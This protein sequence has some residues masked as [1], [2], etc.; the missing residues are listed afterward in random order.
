MKTA[1]LANHE[2][3]KFDAL[4]SHWWDLE[5]EFKT[6]HQ[7]NPLRLGFIE[8]HAGLLD[9]KR[10]LD[11]GCGGGILSEAMAA[12]GALVTGIDM[13]PSPLQIAALHAKGEHLAGKPEINYQQITAEEF[14]E[15]HAAEFDIVTC[16]EL[17]EHVPD[18][19]SLISACQKLCTANGHVFFSTLNRNPKSFLLA[20]VGA[21]YLTAMLPKGT[22]HYANF[23]RPS[24]LSQSCRDAGL[25]PQRLAGIHYNPLNRK[26]SLN[27]DVSVNY[28]LH[29]HN[30]FPE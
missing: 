5:G 14:A 16:M 25:T 22:H 23:I 18:P 15:E 6:L 7:V 20:I 13:A 27:R 11:V 19:G 1:N 4:A 26:F 3:A 21:E 12:A 2:I 30:E 9:G 24:E 8:E 17:L 10:V 28:L 29:C